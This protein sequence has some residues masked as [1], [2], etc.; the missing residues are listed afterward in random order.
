[1]GGCVF[2]VSDCTIY[3][4]PGEQWESEIARYIKYGV[5]PYGDISCTKPH[6]VDEVLRQF[7]HTRQAEIDDLMSGPQHHWRKEGLQLATE[8]SYMSRTKRET[9]NLRK[10]GNR[11]VHVKGK[12]NR[13]YLPMNR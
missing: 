1:M 6:T 4:L 2:N 11:Q 7:R 10:K 3:K 13:R 9:I 5:C 12:G 8:Y